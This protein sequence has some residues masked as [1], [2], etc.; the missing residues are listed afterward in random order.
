ME[1]AESLGQRVKRLRE[2]RGWTKGQLTQRAGLSKTHVRKIEAGQRVNV[3][4][5]VIAK[6]ASAFDI[7]VEELYQAA[8]YIKEGKTPYKRKET[9]EELWRRAMLSTPVTLEV[10]R[11]FTLHAG[12]PVEPAEYLH[13]DRSRATRKDLYA[14]RVQGDC[15]KPEIN[16]GDTII[17]DRRSDVEV[18]DIAACQ[19]KGEVH[20]GRLKKVADELWLENN[21]GRF[22]LEDCEIVALVIE[23][24]RRLK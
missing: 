9:P 24:N 23:V 17:V 3:R 16:D 10:C 14:Y 2:I 13:I 19:V 5:E 6:L 15:L 22:K 12:E 11:D 7:P 8:G 20:I 1:D 18:G 4:A 21:H